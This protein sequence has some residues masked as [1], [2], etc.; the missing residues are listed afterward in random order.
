MPSTLQCAVGKTVREN[1]AEVPR[2]DEIPGN[3]D[4][5]GDAMV[6]VVILGW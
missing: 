6:V 4:G 1:L 5:E 2:L 3:Q